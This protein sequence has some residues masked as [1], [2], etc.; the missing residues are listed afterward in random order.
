M[1]ESEILTPGKKIKKIRKFFGIVQ[2]EIIGSKSTNLLGQIENGKTTL[3][4]N[5]ALIIIENINN[6]ITKRKLGIE[7]I[8]IDWLMEDLQTQINRK[9]YEHIKNLEKKIDFTNEFINYMDE[10]EDF[11]QNYNI[12]E[13]EKIKIINLAIEF[14]NKIY[15]FNKKKIYLLRLKDLYV[16]LNNYELELECMYQI[17]ATYYW[18]KDFR[19]VIDIGMYILNNMKLHFIKNKLLT[20]K[21]YFSI[22]LSYKKIKDDKC[23]NY[24][25]KLQKEMNLKLNEELDIELLKANHY[26]DKKNYK[27]AETICLNIVKNEGDNIIK[28]LTYSTL[29]EIYLE[30]N[31]IKMAENCIYKAI[32]FD[33]KDDDYLIDFYYNALKINIVKCNSDKVKIYFNNSIKKAILTKN[34]QMQYNICNEAYRYFSSIYDFEFILSILD[35][36]SKLDNRNKD[37]IKIYIN[38]IDYFKDKDINI[39]DKI[40]ENLVNL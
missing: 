7:K 28:A 24:L 9:A 31:N 37:I 38:A 6:I 29:S 33:I 23:L 36:I 5:T 13:N 35:T 19:Y 34:V 26:K 2:K 22:A 32:N 10:V 27:K 30:T 25:D 14:Y 15:D 12:L 1:F 39:R 8:T 18:L 3:T 17:M 21:T 20:K 11:M 4:Y 40:L 16:S